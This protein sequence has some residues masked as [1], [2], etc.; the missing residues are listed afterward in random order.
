MA[1]TVSTK[2]IPTADRGGKTGPTNAVAS[3]GSRESTQGAVRDVDVAAPKLPFVRHLAPSHMNRRAA[4]NWQPVFLYV[5]PSAKDFQ[6][7]TS[8]HCGEECVW[9]R[10]TRRLV[11]HP[12]TFS[13]VRSLRPTGRRGARMRFLLLIVTLLVADAAWA[14]EDVPTFYRCGNV[15]SER[16]MP[17]CADAVMRERRLE[18]GRAKKAAENSEKERAAQT[19]LSWWLHKYPNPAAIERER[20]E[21]LQRLRPFMAKN[22]DRTALLEMERRRLVEEC[23]FYAC[24]KATP[25]RLRHAIDENEE[26]L[27]AQRQMASQSALELKWIDERSAWTVTRMKEL[28]KKAPIE[29]LRAGTP[30]FTADSR[31]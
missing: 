16:P 14:G 31:R 18:D 17:A 3:R 8:P 11:T 21:N 9:Y 28:W 13:K 12:V 20:Q 2:R 15:L 30:V 22:A 29:S 23:A 25:D 4:E 7:E 1:G 10:G 27:S 6:V 19:E 26:M 24:S 5:N